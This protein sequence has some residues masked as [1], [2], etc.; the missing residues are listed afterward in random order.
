LLERPDAAERQNFAAS[1]RNLRDAAKTNVAL[2]RASPLTSDAVMTM[3]RHRHSNQ[4]FAPIDV[5]DYVVL[6]GSGDSAP[7]PMSLRAFRVDGRQAINYHPGTWHMNMATL[8]RAG[9]FVMLVHED[10]GPEDCDFCTIAP[11]RF[12][13]L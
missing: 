3:E 11:I 1:I 5:D 10:G 2:I 8:R 9:V 7:A 6:V 12:R 13:G 4:L